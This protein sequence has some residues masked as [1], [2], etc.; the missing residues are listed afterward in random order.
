[1]QLL[2]SPGT[3]K[4]LF[5]HDYIMASV[6]VLSKED[7]ASALRLLKESIRWSEIQN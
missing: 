5:D 2:P 6:G 1:M 3:A 7:P 4:L